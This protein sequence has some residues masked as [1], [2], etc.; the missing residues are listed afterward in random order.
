MVYQIYLPTY[1]Y[2]IRKFKRLYTSKTSGKYTAMPRDRTSRTRRDRRS[3]R[4]EDPDTRDREYTHQDSRN[5]QHEGYARFRHPDGYYAGSEPSAPG[6]EVQDDYDWDAS[7]DGDDELSESDITRRS[8]EW[9]MIPYQDPTIKASPSVA[10]DSTLVLEA[11][12]FDARPSSSRQRRYR[13]RSRDRYHANYNSAEDT[14]YP[15]RR[16]P[17]ERSCSPSPDRHSSRTNNRS[18]RSSQGYCYAPSTRNREREEDHSYPDDYYGYEGEAC[19]QVFYRTI[20][21]ID[22]EYSHYSN[23]EP[24]RYRSSSGTA[25]VTILPAPHSI[26]AVSENHRRGHPGGS[27]TVNL[28]RVTLR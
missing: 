23:E 26:L 5:P 11:P 8:S 2:F 3:H 14:S 27:I 12:A 13:S 15:S 28:G 25:Q 1:S 16:F 18:R 4:S 20:H 6:S 17:V 21:C 7:R 19:S 24:R 9:G 22:G 10:S